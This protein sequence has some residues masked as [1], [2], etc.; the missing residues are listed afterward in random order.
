MALI[1]INV[2]YAVVVIFDYDDATMF[3]L[4]RTQIY[5]FELFIYQVVF[6]LSYTAFLHAHNI[7]LLLLSA[8]TPCPP[9]AIVRMRVCIVEILLR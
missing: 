3:P 2:L 5:S 7:W 6:V 4:L 8:T 9:T 1:A